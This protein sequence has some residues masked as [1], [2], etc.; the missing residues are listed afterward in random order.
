MAT[1]LVT[2]GTSGI[3]HAFARE[4]ADRGYDLVLGPGVDHDV[5]QPPEVAAPHSDEVSH[6]ATEA[7]HHAGLG[8][9]GDVLGAGGRDERRPQLVGQP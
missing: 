1:A 9:V 3:G 7:V 6:A 4:L 2:G 8:V 5:G